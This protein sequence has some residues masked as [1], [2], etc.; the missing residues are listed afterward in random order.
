[1]EKEE[2]RTA[3]KVAVDPANTQ[4]TQVAWMITNYMEM[5]WKPFMTGKAGMKMTNNTIAN[6]GKAMAVHIPRM[7]P[8]F[9]VPKRINAF[10]LDEWTEPF[11]EDME[12]FHEDVEKAAEKAKKK[13]GAAAM[14]RKLAEIMKK[15]KEAKLKA[16]IEKKKAAEA[17]LKG[18]KKGEK[19][20][21][22]NAEAADAEVKA[23]KEEIKKEKVDVAMAQEDSEKADAADEL[24]QKDPV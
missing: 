18:D 4:S 16:D 23:D 2:K 22:A 17:K 1:M 11:F 19:K 24:R 6:A 21:E 20:A 5:F 9:P 8:N 10:K 15:V 7:D 14:K 3:R 13:A 12:A